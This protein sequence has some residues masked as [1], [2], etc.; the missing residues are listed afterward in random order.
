M[1]MRPTT[2]LHPPLMT[3]FGGRPDR[4]DATP[5]VLVLPAMG[6]PARRYGRLADALSGQGLSGAVL[7]WPG[8]GSSPLRADRRHDWGYADLLSHQ[9]VPAI[10][11]LRGGAAAGPVLLL[12]HSLGGHLALM[13]RA[14]GAAGVGGILLMSCGSPWRQ[15]LAARERRQLAVLCALVAVLTPLLGCFPG[16]RVGFGGRQPRRLMREWAT[17]AARGQLP[18]GLLEPP[19][20]AQ[21]AAATAPRVKALSLQGD[22]YAPAA[23]TR[24]LLALAGVPDAQV[25]EVA[26]P[27][28]SG[29]F[30]WLREPAPAAPRLARELR[31]LSPRSRSDQGVGH[32]PS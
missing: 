27:G 18:A 5:P 30:D 29:H 11:A 17:F 7:E 19:T 32:E 24:H 9:L 20:P 14:A 3:A 13:A 4:P 25:D 26:G 22:V 8:T 6:V 23:A 28:L 16:D 15:T 21:A 31:A 10:A 12:G 2:L 1:A